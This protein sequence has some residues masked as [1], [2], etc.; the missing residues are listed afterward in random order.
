MKVSVKWGKEVYNDVD[1][2]TSQP[3]LVFKSQIFTLTGVPPERQKVMIKGGLLKDEEW[4]KQVPKEGM[5]IMMMGSADAIKVDAPVNAPKFV[6]DL[7]EDEQDT[8]ETKQYGSGLANLGN[9]C[10]MN[11]TI[12]CLYSVEGLRAALGQQQVAPADGAGKLVAATKKLFK[13]LEKGGTAFP[14]FEF[15]LTLREQYPQFAQQTGEGLYMQ[16]DAEECFTQVMYCLKEKLKVCGCA[17]GESGVCTNTHRHSSWP[18]ITNQQVCCSSRLQQLLQLAAIPYSVQVAPHAADQQPNLHL[19]FAALPCECAHMHHSAGATP[20][21]PSLPPT[22][23]GEDGSPLLN[24][25]FGVKLE[26]TLKCEE[27]GEEMSVS[28]PMQNNLAYCDHGVYVTLSEAGNQP[29]HASSLVAT[30]VAYQHASFTHSTH[31]STAHV[32]TTSTSWSDAPTLVPAALPC[33]PMPCSP[34]VPLQDSSLAY[35]LKCNIAGDTN[36][37]HQGLALGLVEDREKNSEKLGRLA[38]FKG[39]S[40]VASLP[41]YLTVQLV[42]F[43]YKADV[44]QKAKILRKVGPWARGRAAA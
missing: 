34:F 6:E 24:R 12:Q 27:S 44:Q 31:T 8:L 4:G 29:D 26:T 39:A 3:P 33:P 7:P 38:L 41:P 1:L 18:S 2:D 5:T 40:Q 43:F 21:R 42:R 16:Q 17:Q 13:D 36:Y 25:L 20:H 15:L 35:S 10:Y 28:S 37:L 30:T 19:M 32:C 23:Q 14:P 11:S 22:L 9:T